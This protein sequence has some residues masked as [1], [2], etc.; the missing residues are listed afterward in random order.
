MR[1]LDSDIN[2]KQNLK[3]SFH[4]YTAL[5]IVLFATVSFD[6]ITT[7]SFMYDVGIYRE[8]NYVIR[9]LASSL[10]IVPGVFIGK[11]LQI[12]AAI[13]LSALSLKYSRAILLLIILLNLLAVIINLL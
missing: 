7:L 10:G 3:E 13:G 5:W 4:R 12:V 1:I 2:L 8:K 11:L 6:F 9:W